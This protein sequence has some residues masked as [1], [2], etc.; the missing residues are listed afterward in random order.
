MWNLRLSDKPFNPSI[1][2]KG[3]PT[4]FTIKL[5]HGGEFTNFRDRMYIEGKVNYVDMVDID[6]FFIHDLDAIM[7]G[8]RKVTIEQLDDD[9]EIGTTPVLEQVVETPSKIDANETNVIVHISPEY[10]RKRF[11]KKDKVLSSCS[12][13]LIMEEFD[14][15]LYQQ[16]LEANS[17]VHVGT[18]APEQVQEEQVVNE[19]VVEEDEAINEVVVEDDEAVNEE[20]VEEDQVYVAE[21]I[22]QE[23]VYVVEEIE[24][25]QVEE[26]Y[27]HVTEAQL[28]DF[29]L[30]DYMGFP[31]FQDEGNAGGDEVELEGGDS[32]QD[33]QTDDDDSEDSN[34]WVDEENLIPDVEVDMRDVEVDMKDFH[35]KDS[36][37]DRKR[38]A[39]LKDLGK[40][41]VC[42][43]GQGIVALKEA[44]AAGSTSGDVKKGVRKSQRKRKDLCGPTSIIF[45]K[46]NNKDK[47]K[48]KSVQENDSSCPWVIQASRS[49]T[50][51]N[52]YVK[53]YVQQHTCLNTRKIRSATASFL[54]KQIMDQVETNLTVPIKSL[55]T[56][57]QKKYHVGFSIHSIF[58]AKSQ[59][60]K[61]V[62]RDYTKQ[63][64][65]L[66]DYILELQSTNPDTTVK[67]DLVSEPNLANVT[68]RCFKRIYIWFNSSPCS[69]FPNAEHRFCIRHIHENM[70]KAWRTTE[71]KELL[72]KCAKATTVPEFNRN[73]KLQNK[74]HEI[75][76]GLGHPQKRLPGLRSVQ[77]VHIKA[78]LPQ[79]H[80]TIFGLI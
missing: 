62:E 27:A 59:A 16:I 75:L 80:T 50:E 63:Y 23:Q 43:E 11:W 32:V 71:Y 1:A 38:R 24:R 65:V 25:E 42:S 5:Y 48:D 64:A 6:G 17:V 30:Q 77:D 36:D 73:Q 52:W 45:N 9:E 8:L 46:C 33:S 70:K 78:F 10:N 74:K 39:V 20:V 7:R 40:E 72:W 55:Q 4:L 14:I 22:E 56:Q 44:P 61:L 68:S 31:E 15:G 35:M 76:T 66:R 26:K 58:R 37:L 53:T 41:K 47:G 34:H 19:V 2:Y 67:L 13:K 49:T 57:L 3:H 69:M 29:N 28:D 54:F 21:E 18:T 60:K 51:D 79:K 12:K